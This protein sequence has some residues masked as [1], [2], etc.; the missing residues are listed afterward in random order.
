M[1]AVETSQ[2]L[3]FA[4]EFVSS[5]GVVKEKMIYDDALVKPGPAGIPLSKPLPARKG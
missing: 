2:S 3:L 1:L 5:R 4:V